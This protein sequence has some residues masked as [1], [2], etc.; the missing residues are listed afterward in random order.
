MR[1]YE[2]MFILDADLD[3][4]ANEKAI[5]KVQELIKKNDGKVEN[6]DRWGRRKLAYLIDKHKDGFYVVITFKGESKTINE[7]DRV[8]KLTGEIIRFMIVRIGE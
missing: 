4:E 8:L 3:K 5:E 2:V 6:V 1:T 7:L